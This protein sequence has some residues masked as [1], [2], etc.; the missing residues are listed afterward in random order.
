MVN[1]N[2]GFGNH[3]HL[4]VFCRGLGCILLELA[5]KDGKWLLLMLVTPKD[6]IITM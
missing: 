5:I 1:A 2:L 6:I 3:N 4:N